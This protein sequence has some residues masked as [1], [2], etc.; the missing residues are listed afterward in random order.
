MVF[1]FYV[2]AEGHVGVCGSA[3]SRSPIDV[4]GPAIARGPV[5]VSGLCFWD[6]DGLG[7]Y[8]YLKPC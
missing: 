1:M 7:L 5:D 4:Y 8:Y 6:E 3:M 2:S